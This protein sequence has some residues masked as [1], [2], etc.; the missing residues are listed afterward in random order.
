[1][2][3]RRLFASRRLPRVS[4][5]ILMVLPTLLVVMGPAAPARA[6]A[7]HLVL[8][9]L[10]AR[11]R[12][13]DGRQN[14]SSF[15]EVANP[16]GAAIPLDDVY[17][18]TAQDIINAKFYWNVVGGGDS[19]GGAG[20]NIHCRFPAGMS[21]AAG[22]TMVIA[23]NGT[24]QFQAAYGFLPD[25]E[26][27]EDSFVP[28]QVPE[29]REV[30][31]GSIGAGLGS[32]GTNVPA[33]STTVDSVVL[34]RWNG[35]G[36]LVEDLDYLF[37]GTDTRA[38]VNKT[39][40]A[41]DGPDIDESPTAYA[42][43][44]AVAQQHTAA[45]QSPAFGRALAR[46][47]WAE[48]GET[49]AGGNGATGHNETSENL[50][51]SWELTTTQNPAAPPA[52]WY[53]TAPIV[54]EA[55]HAPLA[56][57][58]GTPVTLSAR[59][60]SHDP[61]A[62]VT[63]RYTVN[64]GAPQQLAAAVGAND[65]WSA[66]LAGLAVADTVRWWLD[67]NTVSGATTVYPFGGA[68]RAHQFGVGEVPTPGDGPAKL[69]LTEV[70]LTPSAGEFVEIHNPNPFAV[71]LHDYYLTD[72][73]YVSSNEVYWRIVQGNPSVETIGGGQF[74]DFH[75]RFP[76]GS[77]LAAGGTITVAL[78]GSDGYEDY[79]H[80]SPDYELF[81][82][83]GGD[84][85][86][87]MV[88]VFAGSIGEPSA[89]F[90][91][92]TNYNVDTQNGEC[93]VLYYWDGT[94]D[95]VTDIDVL[96][97]GTGSSYQFSKNGVSMDGP[98]ADTTPTAYAPER[99]ANQLTPLLFGHAVGE[100]YTRA[101][102]TEGAQAA[103]N[104]NGVDG[105]DELSEN[106]NTTWVVAPA[107]PHVPSEGGGDDGAVVVALDVPARTF[108]P[109]QGE[110]FPISFTADRAWQSRLRILDMQG[111]LVVS[112]YDSAQDSRPRNVRSVAWDGR[113]QTF[114]QVRAGMYVVHLSVVDPSTGEETV[115]T[116]P[117][118]VATRLQK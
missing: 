13:S 25:L 105:R 3:A 108:L 103:S 85:I 35:T 62:A 86:P 21:I 15:I 93:V 59:V 60:L 117:V 46:R 87:E 76:A 71:S 36:D 98:D 19:G 67:A 74:N 99:P 22:D 90:G 104:G 18:S 97:W 29:M 48:D 106:W 107:S 17:I 20:G 92:L 116:A 118:V 12:I 10:V 40:V 66:S 111:R 102:L 37:Y 14:G 77:S 100:S 32:T 109:R 34:Y 110:V 115:E 30:F 64:N 39:G 96:I 9:E 56:P 49:P 53:R 38:R 114:D 51:T 91:L 24:T 44:T 61:L 6:D 47:T 83:S 55:A 68:A 33:M 4:A 57:Y 8:T 79:H 81:E 28:D 89:Q 101:D 31:W 69:L 11:E 94:T 58:A 7:D 72:A 26:L 113:D 82:D 73:L 88:E 75:A 41:V 65:T 43:D 70:C 16:T 45:T 95:L 27:F 23:L 42:A 2:F 5:S 50:A 84:N 63:F 112:L 52:T 1:M 78:L 54:A 80:V